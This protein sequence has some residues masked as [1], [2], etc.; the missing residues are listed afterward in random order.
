MSPRR[1]SAAA[2]SSSALDEIR[3]LR[4]KIEN[5]KS[6]L[7]DRRARAVAEI[8]AVDEALAQLGEVASP[9]P[10][11]TAGGRQSKVRLPREAAPV[12]PGGKR[13]RPARAPE[14]YQEIVDA[15][16][17]G[18]MPVQIAARMKL[19]PK[20]IGNILYR[21]K[22][23]GI[24]ARQSGAKPQIGKTP[25]NDEEPDPAADAAHTSPVPV[26]AAPT[27]PGAQAIPEASSAPDY[28]APV[29]DGLIHRWVSVGGGSASCGESFNGG[30]LRRLAGAVTCPTCV[31]LGEPDEEATREPLP[32]GW[33]QRWLS[34]EQMEAFRAVCIEGVSC[35]TAAAYAGVTSNVISWRLNSARQTIRRLTTWETEREAEG[36]PLTERDRQP[37]PSRKDS[38]DPLLAILR[39]PAPL[40]IV[41]PP[42]IDDALVAS[43]KCTG[44]DRARSKMKVINGR[45][46]C[47]TIAPTR[48]TR[49]ERRLSE[50]MPTPGGVDRPLTRSDCEA[51]PG[52]PCPWVSC[53]HHLYLDVNPETGA[54][55][56]NFPHLEVWEMAETCSLDVADRGGITLEE[57][58]AILNLTRER[59][60][61]VEVRG[62]SKIKDDTDGELGEFPE[63]FAS[64]LGA[65]VG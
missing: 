1:S 8:S 16:A 33:I 44:L 26:A 15:R 41:P 5:A 18:E 36:A 9:P 10:V 34:H 6:E 39:S 30:R 2:F 7:R 61:Q 37:P 47:K 45:T 63:R 28:P 56:L 60:R 38:S 3:E 21:A 52:R 55:K 48:L 29:D 40:A 22:K 23:L 32:P 62:L 46:R 43:M 13:G 4:D 51:D 31:D 59:I 54:I 58:G 27:A 42:D 49:D 25:A 64:P 50:M 17:A 12:A 57:V 19:S 35:Q 24:A 20:S 11:A 14:G 53:S 65:V